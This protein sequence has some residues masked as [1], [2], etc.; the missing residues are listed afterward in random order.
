MHKRSNWQKYI[1]LLEKKQ[2]PE[3]AR[4]WYVRR[5]EKFLDTYS[6]K[7]LGEIS[8]SEIENY[9]Q[10][11]SRTEQLHD[12]QF[13]QAVDALQILLFDLSDTAASREVD[14]NYWREAAQ[15][16]PRNHS[17]LA[18][19]F[20]VDQ[21][22]EESI[23]TNRAI[24]TEHR[25]VLQQT[26]RLIRLRHYSIR[27]ERSYIDW[28]VRFFKFTGYKPLA[29]LNADNVES[30]LSHLAVD[31]KV[32]AST[33]NQALNAIVFLLTKVLEKPRE[34]F[35]F[36]H[37]KRPKR[38]PVVLSQAEVSRLLGHLS[39]IYLLM[40]GLMYGTGM[41]LM[42][43]V[44]LRVKD[45]DFDYG[46]IIIRD[47]KGNKD[48]VV[49][50]PER[51]QPALEQQ[52]RSVAVQHKADIEAGANGVFLP[53]ALARKYPGAGKELIWQ[54]VFPA[55]K[56]SVD[57]RSTAVRRHHLH[58][59]TLQR[60]IKTAVKQ[61][62]IRKKISSHTLRHSF[63]T[64]LLESGYDIRTVQELLGHSDVN[65]TMIYTHVLNKPGLAV[66][67]PADMLPT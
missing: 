41:R 1:D 37:S 57:P 26:I 22:V 28:I 18:V 47:A 33:Q 55:A 17:T 6:N 31:K 10:S 30:F 12:W 56:L 15:S 14:W 24:S 66:K 58:E 21:M 11:L 49:P 32:A 59:T 48:R 44:R 29:S 3:R 43:C 54:Y 27:T 13:K 65:T 36:K 39:G 25:D 23:G 40:T 2:V 7:K 64:H 61:S 34:E 5:I 52:I 20:S 9:L 19:D 16:L 60:A 8:A 51:Y 42:E 4:R 45:A 63:A 53:N 46:Q 38:L 67:S 50:I 35:N 62:A